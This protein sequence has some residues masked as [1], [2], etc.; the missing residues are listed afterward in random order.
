M[1]IAVA[2]RTC[3]KCKADL[4]L[5]AFHKAKHNPSGLQRWCR[6]CS[7][8]YRRH[9]HNTVPEYRAKRHESQ[10]RLYRK[11]P[12]AW[13]IRVRRNEIERKYG[14]TIDQYQALLVLQDN[15]C[16]L[17]GTSEPR[18][19]GSWHVDHNH[20]TGDVRGLLC[21]PCNT[22][23][24]TYEKFKRRFGQEVIE[25]YLANAAVKRNKSKK[26]R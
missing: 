2:L 7:N 18:G 10:R 23:L 13:S 15:K 5:T 22:A 14:I 11:D 16:A 3:T 12:V 1:N 4:P 9:R 21:H 20:E 24:G 8:A 6:D 17:C 25:R 19:K 26:R